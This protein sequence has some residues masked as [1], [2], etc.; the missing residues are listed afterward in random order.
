VARKLL[1]WA[2]KIDLQ[3]SVKRTLDFFLRESVNSQRPDAVKS[4]R[5]KSEAGLP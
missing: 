1:G 2:P 5:Q 4:G 3:Q